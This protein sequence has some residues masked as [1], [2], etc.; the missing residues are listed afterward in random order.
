MENKK[1]TIALLNI[2]SKIIEILNNR[3]EMDNGD[4]Q[5]AIEAQVRIAYLLGKGKINL[6]LDN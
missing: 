6:E 4:F 1:E 2:S 5:G 3:D